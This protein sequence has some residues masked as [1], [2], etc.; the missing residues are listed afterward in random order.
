MAELSKNTP[1]ADVL[2]MYTPTRLT[3][4]YAKEGKNK[5][6]KAIH[7]SL[8]MAVLAGLFIALGSAVSS[9]ATHSIT[10]ISTARV[11]S[12]LL[13]PFGLGMVILLG[14]E[15]F[16][17]STLICIS[18][19]SGETTTFKMLRSW[20]IVYLGNF[21]GAVLLAAACA[22]FGQMDQSAGA[23]GAYTIKVAAAKASL[24]FSS[25]LVMGIFCNILVCTGVLC[26]LSAKDTAGRIM[27]AYIPVAFFII[28][29]FEHC[30]ANMY[31]IPAGIFA[32]QNPQ[33]ASL[34]MEMGASIAELSWKN[35]F[36]NNLLP[37]TLGNILGGVFIGV[38][39]WVCNLRPTGRRFKERKT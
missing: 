14:G 18:V 4:N 7:K 3:Q 21:I 10:D 8:I 9:T 5:A 17:G 2:N 22:W 29:G 15:L 1:K 13:F 33:Y 32:L 20:C 39:M 34:A 16:T 26:S 28:C 31:Y 6:E 35:F 27:G 12:G 30:V 11:I 23:L 25:A 19:L 24:P 37:V 38:S 36:L